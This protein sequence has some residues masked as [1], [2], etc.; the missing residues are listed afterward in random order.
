MVA[1]LNFIPYLGPLTGIVCITLGAVLSFNSFT[2]ALL[3]PAV[4]L[5]I[6]TLEGNFITPWVMGRSLTLNPVMILLSLIFW[7]WLWGVPGIILAVP[8]PGRLQNLLLAHRADAT[9]GRVS[10]LN[11]FAAFVSA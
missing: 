2:Y 6:A 5:A 1:V 7:G 10:K 9:S 3:F 11:Y 8:I 4:Y